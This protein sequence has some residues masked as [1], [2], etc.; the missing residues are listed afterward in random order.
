M[1]CLCK[2]EAAGSLG[3]GHNPSL[4]PDIVPGKPTSEQEGQVVV[5]NGDAKNVR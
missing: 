5:Q 1:N 3:S 4:V 2:D